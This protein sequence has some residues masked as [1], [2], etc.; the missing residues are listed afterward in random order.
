[1]TLKLFKYPLP[2]PYRVTTS[3]IYFLSAITVRTVNHSQNTIRRTVARNI[4]YYFDIASKR[5]NTRGILPVK[6]LISANPVKVETVVDDGDMFN[7]VVICQ[8]LLCNVLY[9]IVMCNVLLPK[10]ILDL[11]GFQYEMNFTSIPRG[12][13]GI[14][15]ISDILHEKY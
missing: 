9:Y 3:F 8:Y 15:A 1:M 13:R 6:M 4:S 2:I 10:S 5:T 7:Y 11:R 12:L 14:L